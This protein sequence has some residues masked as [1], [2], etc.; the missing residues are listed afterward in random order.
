MSETIYRF[1]ECNGRTG[2]MKDTTQIDKKGELESSE[3][4]A[5]LR[6]QA[7][8]RGW[9]STGNYDLCPECYE[10]FFGEKKHATHG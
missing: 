1:L 2:C 4:K 3:S 7:K 6:G 8:G 10:S 5:I 9:H